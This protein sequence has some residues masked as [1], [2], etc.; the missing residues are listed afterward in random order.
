MAATFEFGTLHNF[1]SLVKHWSQYSA[2]LQTDR[3]LTENAT[4]CDIQ[5]G[6]E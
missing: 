6:L 2:V 5:S 3:K 4:D 1:S